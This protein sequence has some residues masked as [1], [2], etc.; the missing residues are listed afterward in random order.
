[1]STT[2]LPTPIPAGLFPLD[3]VTVTPPG[4]PTNTLHLVVY[5]PKGE[6]TGHSQVTQTTNPSVNVTSHV[7]GTWRYELTGG[8]FP[9]T[10]SVVL[11]GWPEI[12]WPPRGGIGPVIPENYRATLHLSPKGSVIS[13][14]YRDAAGEWVSV[15]E[16]PVKVSF[17]AHA[18]AAA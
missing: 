18:A 9:G 3:V 17:G 8:G 12:K 2:A 14:D 11:Q 16:Q 5:T 10:V 4:A 1:M 15:G 6:V 13:Y 7:T